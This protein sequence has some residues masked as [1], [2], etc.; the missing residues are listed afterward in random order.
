MLAMQAPFAIAAYPMVVTSVTERADAMERFA[1]NPLRYAV[2][3]APSNADI[4]L[5]SGASRSSRLR[6]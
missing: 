3:L 5:E 4:N 6:R 1:D 2:G